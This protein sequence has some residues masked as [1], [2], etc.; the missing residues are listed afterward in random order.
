MVH[1]RSRH[2]CKRTDLIRRLKAKEALTNAALII[3]S[4]GQQFLEATQSTVIT[5]FRVICQKGL[6]EEP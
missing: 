1:H 5:G 2:R 3:K 4:E 6:L